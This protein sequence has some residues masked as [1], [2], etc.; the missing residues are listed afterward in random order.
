MSDQVLLGFSQRIGKSLAG[1]HELRGGSLPVFTIE[2]GLNREELSGLFSATRAAL[3]RA[4]M[5]RLLEESTY[6]TVIVI[7]TEVGYSYAGVGTEYWPRL[8]NALDTELDENDRELIAARFLKAHRAFGIKRPPDTPLNR[9]YRRIAWP[10]TNAL[11]PMEIHRPLASA[12]RTILASGGQAFRGEALV[13]G[14]RNT[15][16]GM[17]SRRLESW[18]Q[19]ASTA[20]ELCSRLLDDRVEEGWLSSGIV[21]RIARDLRSDPEARKR[22]DEARAGGRRLASGRSS[23]SLPSARY[24]LSLANDRPVRLL[25][26]GPLLPAALRHEIIDAMQSPSD[27][28]QLAGTDRMIELDRFLAGDVVD[29]YRPQE[30]PPDPAIVRPDGSASPTQTAERL[31]RELQPPAAERFAITQDPTEAVSANE[32]EF[33]A[34]ARTIALR[35]LPP[36]A[37]AE[38]EGGLAEN[39]PNV[40]YSMKERSLGEGDCLPL[41]GLVMSGGL[42]GSTM[43]FADQ[44]PIVVGPMRAEALAF[45]GDS[46]V[47]QVETSP[48]DCVMIDAPPGAYRVEARGGSGARSRSFQLVLPERFG[49][50]AASVR[51]EPEQPAKDAFLAGDFTV[52]IS[53][54]VPLE[55]V[56]LRLEIRDARGECCE[57]HHTIERL[58]ARLWGRSPIFSDLRDWLSDES[59]DSFE[60][61]ILSVGASGIGTTTVELEPPEREFSFDIETKSWSSEDEA[62]AHA[63]LLATAHSPLLQPASRQAGRGRASIELFVPAIAEDSF[64]SQGLCVSRSGS[65]RLGDL[66]EP[67]VPKLLREAASRANGVGL[68]PVIEALV[69]WRLAAAA[70]GLAELQRRWV[71]SAVQKW[72]VEQLCGVAWV[73][74]EES[75]EMDAISPHAALGNVLLKLRD[76]GRIDLPRIVNREDDRLIRSLLETGFRQA[77]PRLV[78]ALEA[79]GSGQEQRSNEIHERLD[80]A[81]SEAHERFLRSPHRTSA[82]KF[83]EPDF[84]MELDAWRDALKSAMAAGRLPRFQKLVLPRPRWQVLASADFG[85]MSDDDLVSLLDECH[86]DARRQRGRRWIDRGDLRA[87][88]QVWL[89]PRSLLTEQDWR[90]R[91]CRFL[92]DRPT[93]RSVRYVALRREFASEHAV[94]LEISP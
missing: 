51:F 33:A 44:F 41:A 18:L 62:N 94:S 50:S 47:S 53:A 25:L 64:L 77:V 34:A 58:P 85:A 72:V 43:V 61:A 42:E 83:D 6:L 46:A 45:H 73:A 59:R 88:L 21:M 4:S 31:L 20:A 9:L 23:L 5:P 13:E 2:H 76:G 36:N 78:E 30:R 56:D 81:V 82:S 71:E 37:V 52:R 17:W 60:P 3:R 39:W 40:R 28:L 65:F 11:A 7:A 8:E 79:I 29:L 10:V 66:A 27:R 80:I 74:A 86:L 84:T 35:W 89:D 1:L 24:V 57:A 26:K 92:S 67:P 54:P 90:D 12:L 16:S 91:V 32:T 14:L 48:G 15:A 55:D 38:M 75:L 22:L 19:D 49:A 69:A 87:M 68:L 63:S 70:S 93:A